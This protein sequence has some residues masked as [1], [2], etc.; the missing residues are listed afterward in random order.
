MATPPQKHSRQDLCSQAG[1]VQRTSGFLEGRLYRDKHQR[2]CLR[3]PGAPEHQAITCTS[4][5]PL[6]V[7]L[8]RAWI[9]GHVEG[10][11]QDYWLFA[12]TGGKFLLSEQMKARYSEHWR[13]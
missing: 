9:A 3:K 8:N 10:D 2:Y 5:C 13:R 6:E 11:G 4:G 7:W 1:Q 12:Q